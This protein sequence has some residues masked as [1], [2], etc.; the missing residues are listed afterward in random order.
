MPKLSSTAPPAPFLGP[1]CSMAGG[2]ALSALFPC[3][4]V[5]IPIGR[6][7]GCGALAGAGAGLGRGSLLGVISGLVSRWSVLPVRGLAGRRLSVRIWVK[8]G[9]VAVA[10]LLIIA[11][12]LLRGTIG[13]TVWIGAPV[14]LP[15]N[16]ANRTSQ[17]TADGC[18]L[19]WIGAIGAGPYGC[20]HGSAQTRARVSVRILRGGTSHQK[21]QGQQ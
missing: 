20:P 12:S 7:L 6:T 14:D 17:Q 9:C 4:S 5:G 21:S 13:R 18:T 15:G 2:L 3:A 11:I 1:E 19:P 16:A 10:G 8:W